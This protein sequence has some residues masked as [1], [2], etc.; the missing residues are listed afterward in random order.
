MLI[1]GL[2]LLTTTM[3]SLPTHRPQLQAAA[4]QQSEALVALAQRME[5]MERDIRD[6]GGWQFE[7]HQCQGIIQ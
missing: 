7:W 3:L 1:T 6:T 5:R 2:V 4:G